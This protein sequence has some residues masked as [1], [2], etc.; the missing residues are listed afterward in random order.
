MRL[1]KGFPF[2]RALHHHKHDTWQCCGKWQN[3][4]CSLLAT[5]DQHTYATTNRSHPAAGAKLLARVHTRAY[6]SRPAEA[7][8]TFGRAHDS[9][10][11]THPLR[12]LY[13]RSCRTQK[14]T[15]IRMYKYTE[16]GVQNTLTAEVQ[17]HS[18]LKYRYV[19]T[20]CTG[21]QLLDVKKK[22]VKTYQHGI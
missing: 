17:V 13:I 19:Q 2:R 15:A 10:P 4:I 1:W 9:L 11:R 22:F 20:E 3:Q 12:V 8:C 6:M 21:I 5:I 18:N 14:I 16:N 7:P